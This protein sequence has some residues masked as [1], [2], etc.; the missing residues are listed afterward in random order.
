[1]LSYRVDLHTS[2]NVLC[3]DLNLIS[4]SLVARLPARH[5]FKCSVSLFTSENWSVLGYV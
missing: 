5:G 3:D 1:M 2:S 4:V